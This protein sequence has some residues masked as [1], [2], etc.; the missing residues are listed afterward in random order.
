MA[1]H[2]VSATCVQE[3]GFFFAANIHCFVASG[4]E[5]AAPWGIDW[6]GHFSFERSPHSSSGRIRDRDR[7]E[8]SLG[9]GVEGRTVKFFCFC[10]FDNSSEVHNC[11]SV[12]YALHDAQIVSDEQVG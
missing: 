3:S 11:N 2:E 8:K 9:V 1:S 5:S 7:G 12:A 4:I 6:A 10:E